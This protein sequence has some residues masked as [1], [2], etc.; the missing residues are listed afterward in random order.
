MRRAGHVSC[1]TWLRWP[2]G[3]KPP[4]R[5]FWWVATPGG[6]TW[7]PE[8]DL[9]LAG[10]PEDLQSGR[11]AVLANMEVWAPRTPPPCLPP[12]EASVDAANHLFRMPDLHNID[13]PREVGLGAPGG[14]RVN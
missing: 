4:G 10:K 7:V 11:W 12:V 5:I 9:R 2:V 3:K 13:G 6:S 14:C 8:G 1:H